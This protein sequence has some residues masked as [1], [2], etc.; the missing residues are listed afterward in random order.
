MRT[1][2]GK[3]LLTRKL[4]SLS[5]SAPDRL[6]APDNLSCPTSLN[7]NSKLAIQRQYSASLGSPGGEKE[8]TVMFASAPGTYTDTNSFRAEKLKGDASESFGFAAFVDPLG[9]P[10]D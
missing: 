2:L 6:S 4:E 8:V 1:W 9:V 7:L 5:S 10:F 3:D